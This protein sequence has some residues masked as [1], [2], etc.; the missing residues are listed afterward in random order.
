MVDWEINDPILEFLYHN[1]YNSGVMLIISY[2]SCKIEQT[3]DQTYNLPAKMSKRLT[4][5]ITY[6]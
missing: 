1:V 3:A 6:L 4:K 5:L 2:L